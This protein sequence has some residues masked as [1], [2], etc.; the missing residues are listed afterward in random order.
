MIVVAVNDLND[1]MVMY[2][3]H[4]RFTEP[5]ANGGEWDGESL[6][7]TTNTISYQA[8]DSELIASNKDAGAAW[9]ADRYG[10]PSFT[11][12]DIRGGDVI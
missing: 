12:G 2:G 4:F 3:L 10:D 1:G 7:S 8:T 5:Y 9:I 6:T 11:A